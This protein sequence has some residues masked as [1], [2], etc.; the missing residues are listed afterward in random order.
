VEALFNG[1]LALAGRDQETI[2]FACWP[3]MPD[4]SIYLRVKLVSIFSLIKTLS[5]FF[6]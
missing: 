6:Q 3:G 2:V 4:F 1:T 5:R